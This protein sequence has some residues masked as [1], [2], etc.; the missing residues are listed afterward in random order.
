MKYNHYY[1]ELG[2]KPNDFPFEE[3]EDIADRNQE[4]EEG[5]SNCEFWNLDYTLALHIYGRLRYFQEYCLYAYPA[6]MTKE[7]WEE[8]I[9]K[10]IKGF[11][12]YLIEEEKDWSLSNQEQKRISKNRRKQINYAFRLLIKYWGEFWY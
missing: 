1:Q 9:K 10:I 6:S 2:L 4:D 7:K 12:L 3:Y 11:K 5:F 8:I